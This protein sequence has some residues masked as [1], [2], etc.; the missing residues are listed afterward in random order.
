MDLLL[1][2]DIDTTEVDGVR[3]L[4]RVAKICEGYGLRVQYSVFE[5]R[6]APARFEMLVGEL[7]DVIDVDKDSVNVYRVPGLSEARTSLGRPLMFKSDG[8]WVM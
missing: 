4:A 8:P 3:R 7:L 6:L 2:Y 5:M 1:T